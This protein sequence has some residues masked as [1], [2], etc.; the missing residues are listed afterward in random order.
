MAARTDQSKGAPQAFE[1][2]VPVGPYQGLLTPQKG[3]CTLWSERSVH[4]GIRG[5]ASAPSPQARS[6]GVERI[7]E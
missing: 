7:R 2:G 4:F 1:M 6:S 3:G 5:D